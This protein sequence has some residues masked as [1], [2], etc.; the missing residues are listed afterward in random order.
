M[1]KTARDKDRA[2]AHSGQNGLANGVE[3]EGDVDDTALGE[4]GAATDADP[5]ASGSK[6]IVIHPGS[7]NLRI[8]LASDALPKTI[9]MVVA[10][11]SSEN[12]WE[13]LEPKPKRRKL[14]NGEEPEDP[15]QTFNEDFQ[16]QFAT[17]TVDLKNRMRRKARRIVPNCREVAISHN[18]KY[19]PNV[20]PELNDTSRVEWTEVNPPSATTSPGHFV[21]H[22]ALRIPDD[23]NPRYKLSWPL[24][25][26]YFNE[27]DYTSKDAIVRDISAIL[28]DA[29]ENQLNIPRK[30]DRAQYGCVYVIPDIY[31]RTYVS[32]IL[33]LLLRELGFGRVCFIQESMAGSFGAGYATCVIVDVGAQKTSICCVEEGMCVE[34]SRINLR[35]GGFDVTETF[36]RM[37]LTDSFPYSDINLRRRYDFLLA[38]ELKQKFC[39]L[40]VMDFMQ[41]QFEFYLRVAGQD[42]RQYYFRAYD[43]VILAPMVRF[44]SERINQRSS[45]ADT[46]QGYY[47]PSIFDNSEK[48][49]RRR[50]V[51]KR[52]YDLYDGSPNDHISAAQA[53]ILAMAPQPEGMTNGK[54]PSVENMTNG[55]ANGKLPKSA[56]SRLAASN[57]GK[58]TPQQTTPALEDGEGVG[59]RAGTPQPGDKDNAA[60]QNDPVMD[61]IHSA[62][63]RDRTLAVMPLGQAIAL[64]IEQGS[65]GDD[66]KTRDFVGGI[67][68]IGGGAQTPMFRQFL[69]E[70]LGETQT[71]F[72]KDIMVAPPPREIDA[73]VLAWKGASVFGKLTGTND[74]WIGTMEYDRL[75]SRLLNY[76][77]L[78]SW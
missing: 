8:G 76:K 66:R 65:K 54:P 19:A 53:Q 71:K 33:D 50:S 37:M 63:I 5:E 7:Q 72:R 16:A 22:A 10:R 61:M 56:A 1:A 27:E 14:D 34:S 15:K 51:V 55:L 40:S 39:T 77:C 31:E 36:I 62:D 11:K 44:R 26:V 9:P 78:W 73:Q 47:F 52:S 21:G 6:V 75:G 4:D 58:D 13:T 32:T 49:K 28:E 30:R 45:F 57:A 12:E 17:M 46:E 35:Y 24:S 25:Y 43:E 59:D 20:M 38:D 74:S 3:V 41:Q 42:T 68:P 70:E 29:I 67:I 64:S 18:R 48:L 23:S 60:M 2:L 69:E